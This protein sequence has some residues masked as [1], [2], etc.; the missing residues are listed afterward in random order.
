MTTL[1]TLTTLIFDLGGVLIDWNPEYVFRE[2]IPDT[3]RRK[4][5]FDHIC[6]HDW[7]VEQDAGR[8]IAVATQ[9]LVEQHPNSSLLW[10][11][12][13]DAGRADCGNRGAAS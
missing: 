4:F 8:R 6:T 5:F 7:N 2:V 3:E 1:N 11:L 13:R 10:P 12:G 9:L